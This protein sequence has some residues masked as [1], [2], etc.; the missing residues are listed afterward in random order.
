MNL[1]FCDTETGGLDEEVTSLLSVGFAVWNNYKI[2]STLEIFIKEPVLRVTPSALQV[3]QIDLREFNQIGVSVEEARNRIEQFI[4]QNFGLHKGKVK[5]AGINIK[6]DINYIKKCFGKKFF[7]KWFSH[8]SV[9]L[10]SAVTFL[11]IKN[12]ISEDCSSSE[13]AYKYF[14]INK[15]KVE[16]RALKDC[17]HEIEL[18]EKLLRLK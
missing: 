16:H 6:F 17:L 10:Q 11:Y 13:K 5:L 14:N 3:N 8:R 1:L 12:T 18:F 15:G 2:E 7:N 9:D 4:Y